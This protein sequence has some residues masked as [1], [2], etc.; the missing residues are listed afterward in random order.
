MKIAIWGAGE[1]G[2]YIIGQLRQNND[3]HIICIIDNYIKNDIN[4]AGIEIVSP[5]DYLQRYNEETDCVIVTFLNGICIR[6][7]LQKMGIIKWGI[8]ND[9][10][11]HK[12]LSLSCNLEED[13]YII[14]NTDKEVDLPVMETLETNVVDYCN[15]NCKGCSH[16]SNIFEKGAQI[17]YEIFERDIKFLAEKLFIKRFNLLGGEILLS[18][19][20]IDYIKCLKRYMAKTYIVLITNGLLIPKLSEQSLMELAEFQIEIEITLYP[21][22][23]KIKEKLKET[24]DHY[25]IRYLLRDNVLTFGK[26]IDLKGENDPQ[27]SQKSCR[28]HTCQFLRD[29]KIYKCPFSALGNH[30]FDYYGIP[31]HFNEGVD[32]YNKDMDWKKIPN[33]LR[34][35]PIGL[36][37]YCGA[38]ERFRWATSIQPKKEE[39]LI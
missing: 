27:K 9:F 2:K 32:I 15:L 6:N 22:T 31:L 3:I 16:F 39:W 13:P 14:W 33:Q 4:I 29:G 18:A 21:P 8:V 10:V 17:P 11:F 35:E 23:F 38:E 24:L 37:R 26:N 1:F 19:R 12:K 20:L 5:A 36:C 28:E 25:G 30:F 34:E 7:Q